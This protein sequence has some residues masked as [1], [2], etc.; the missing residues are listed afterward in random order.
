MEETVLA[1][2]VVLV[3][4][5]GT[6]KVAVVVT[7][8]SIARSCGGSSRRK[9]SCIYNSSNGSSTPNTSQDSGC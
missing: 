8:N 4:V 7:H 1:V 2:T 9:R 5:V 6:V 3:S